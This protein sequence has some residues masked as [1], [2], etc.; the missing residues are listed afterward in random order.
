MASQ[1][2]G[3]ANSRK[4]PYP[5]YW[6]VL[7]VGI[8][9]L[10]LSLVTVL[11]SSSI[12]G[13]TV[14][15]IGYLSKGTS[16]HL[17][18]ND[19]PGL[20]TI[21]TH[22]A[23]N[24]KGGKLLAEVD[25][26]IVFDQPYVVKFKVSSVGRFGPMQFSFKVKEQD[27]L[28]KGMTRDGLLLYHGLKE[29]QLQLLKVNHGYIYYVV[30]VPDMGSY[31]LGKVSAPSLPSPEVKNPDIDNPPLQDKEASL[32]E[33]GR[34]PLVGKAAETSESKGFFAKI[35]DFFRNLFS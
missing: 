21:F 1:K 19:V 3:S 29:Y 11:S 9:V 12:T 28:D 2:R 32:Y 31:V 35:G 34:Q 14:Q 25:N 16:L 4:L 15:N 26:S 10:G 27:L 20:E 8:L 13:N 33:G 24:I 6:V 17:S 18:V 5:N 23:E 22:A 30:T 7:S